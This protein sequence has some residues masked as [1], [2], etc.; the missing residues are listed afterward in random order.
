MPVKLRRW[1][2]IIL[3]LTLAALA[4][5]GAAFYVMRIKGAQETGTLEIRDAASGRVYGKWP[6]EEGEEFALEFVHSVQQSPVR[7]IFTVEKKNDP[8]GKGAFFFF[9]SGHAKRFGSG[10]DNEQGRGR[11]AYQ[12]FQ[13]LIQRA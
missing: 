4:I 3:N 7:E 13:Y 10:A 9:R 6:L 2:G 8:A 5:S 12:R 1:Y 11:R